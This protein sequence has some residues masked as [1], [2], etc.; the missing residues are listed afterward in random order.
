MKKSLISLVLAGASIAGVSQSKADILKDL[1]LTVPGEYHQSQPI[2]PILKFESEKGL[3]SYTVSV[4]ENNKEVYK[5]D[6]L[7]LSLK[8]SG[9][10]KQALL[11]EFVPQSSDPE[12]YAAL[13]ELD[14]ISGEYS[15]ELI[16]TNHVKLDSVP[17]P[18]TL[19]ILLGGAYILRKR[20]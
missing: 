14:F 18:A 19:P 1:E 7:F 12:I 8:G 9:L 15:P 13:Q 16:Y 10:Q 11:P 2:Q 4:F 20:R 3:Q 17:E 6:L 5:K